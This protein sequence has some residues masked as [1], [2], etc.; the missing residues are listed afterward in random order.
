M[1]FPLWVQNVWYSLLSFV[2]FLF[3]V[4]MLTL[5]LHLLG[6]G[7]KSTSFSPGFY[8]RRPSKCDTICW[9]FDNLSGFFYCPQLIVCADEIKRCGWYLWDAGDADS[10]AHKN[11]K[12]KLDISSFLTHSPTL[13]GLICV[14][15][16]MVIVLLQKMIGDVNGED[17]WFMWGF[18]L[19]RQGVGINFFYFS[20]CF[21]CCCLLCFHDWCMTVVVFVFFVPSMLC[22]L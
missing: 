18:V 8:V 16:I 17:G 15:N 3:C 6:L 14:R 12:C 21:L 19:E 4:S 5:S 20:F 2:F 9:R 1:G 10:R 22:F 7:S 11:P 13:D